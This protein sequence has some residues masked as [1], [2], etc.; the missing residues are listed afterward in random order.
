M[1]R[2]KEY[3]FP[4]EGWT[5]GYLLLHHLDSDDRVRFS[6]CQ[7]QNNNRDLMIRVVADD[8][9]KCLASAKSSALSVVRSVIQASTDAVGAY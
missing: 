7:L 1:S 6:G 4:G 5:L 9:D 3:N 2:Q 8:P